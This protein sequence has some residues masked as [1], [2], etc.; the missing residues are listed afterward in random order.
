M[1]EPPFNKTPGLPFVELSTIDSTNNYA[2][3]KIHEGLAQHGMAFFAHEQVAGKG[4]R[5]KSWTT[6]KKTSLILSIILDPSPLQLTQQFQLSAC[7]A[8][9]A[10]E[11]LNKYD[12]DK[13]RIKWPNDLYW[14]DRKAGGILIE[15][16]IGSRN[17]DVNESLGWRW[18]VV[19]IGININQVTFPTDLKNPISLRQLTGKE[20][21]TVEL[22]K[23][24][25]AVFGKNFQ[26]LV[27]GGFD[28]IYHLYTSCLYKKDQVVKL[29][30]DNRL[31]HA[32]IKTVSPLGRLVV[33]HAMEEE[34]EFGSI[35]WV[36][37]P[38]SPK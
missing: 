7:V 27:A 26:H 3:T 1:P 15:N 8:V 28:E 10:C 4:Q 35:E 22:A 24:F 33:Q 2:L 17:T 29:R 9:S 11:F 13:T 19:G 20:F 32:T 38:L 12:D 25:C 14:H 30:K 16:V 6:E 21:N 31:F 36:I 18:A 23:E 34:F 5:N 37:P